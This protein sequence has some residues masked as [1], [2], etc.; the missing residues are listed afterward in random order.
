MIIVMNNKTYILD[1]SYINGFELIRLD[2]IGNINFLLQLNNHLPV[3]MKNKLLKYIKNSQYY[4]S[5]N[6]F[7]V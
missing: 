3:N 4:I 5:K 6:V 7:T 2:T 1:S